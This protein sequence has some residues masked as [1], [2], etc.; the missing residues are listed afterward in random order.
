MVKTKTKKLNRSNK[1][2]V[3]SGRD[4][5]VG[6]ADGVYILKLAIY[7]ILGAFWLRISFNGTQ[8]PIPIGAII[9]LFIIKYEKYRIDRKIEYAILLLSMFIG[10]W[11]PPGI[12]FV[13]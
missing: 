12:E 5:A 1:S 6:E 9:G 4:T 3:T 8:L 11:L 10:F 2:F 13:L 7:L